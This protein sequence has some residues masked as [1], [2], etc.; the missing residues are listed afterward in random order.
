MAQTDHE[1]GQ[2]D[3]IGKK[4]DKHG[5]RK[6]LHW[7]QTGPKREGKHEIDDAGNQ[8]LNRGDPGCVRQRHLAR[9]IVVDA[10]R[11]AGTQHRK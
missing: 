1:Q 2:A 9:Q 4:T 10:P 8:P 6:V 5:R 3:T 7:R 11:E